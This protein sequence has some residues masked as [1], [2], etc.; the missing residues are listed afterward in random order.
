MF[1]FFFA[2]PPHKTKKRFPET[3]QKNG[4]TLLQWQV[5]KHVRIHVLVPLAK[6]ILLN[7]A[8]YA[9]RNAT[10][11][12]AYMASN[13]FLLG[14]RQVSLELIAHSKPWHSDA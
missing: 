6:R 13:L 7:T 5:S 3:L 11:S 12:K 8:V 1:E 10:R 4:I 9:L 14:I 2:L